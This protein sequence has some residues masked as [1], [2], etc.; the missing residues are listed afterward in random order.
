MSSMSPKLASASTNVASPVDPPFTFIHQDKGLLGLLEGLPPI[1]RG[2]AWVYVGRGIATGKIK[3]GVFFM[4][5]EM[6]C[7]NSSSLPSCAGKAQVTRL[8]LAGSPNTALHTFIDVNKIPARECG[9]LRDMI[10]ALNAGA[11]VAG[12]ANSLPL[13]E[14]IVRHTGMAVPPHASSEKR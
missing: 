9:G 2:Q 8:S 14:A 1:E 11:E 12:D 7:D 6:W 10:V 5:H 3:A 13:R 4:S